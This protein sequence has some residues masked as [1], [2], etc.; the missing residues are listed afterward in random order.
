MT[1]FKEGFKGSGFIVQGC[2][3]ELGILSPC[4]PIYETT[5]S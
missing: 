2:G 1:G 4:F 5:R 3:E